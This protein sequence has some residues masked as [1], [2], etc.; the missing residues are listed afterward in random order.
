MPLRNRE[1]FHLFAVDR[2]SV[3][4]S[5]R[6]IHRL[7][8]IT[9]EKKKKKPQLR[10]EIVFLFENSPSQAAIDSPTLLSRVEE[11]TVFQRLSFPTATRVQVLIIIFRLR[12]HEKKK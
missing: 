6:V 8:V 5:V 9:F 4:I 3:W 2:A 7:L 11:K 1:V 10:A 12:A